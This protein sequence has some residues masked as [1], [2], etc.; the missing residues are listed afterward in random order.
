MA[1]K[2]NPGWSVVLKKEARGAR[3]STA[4]VELCLGQEESHGDR[5]V[6]TIME[7]DRR[8]AGEENDVVD[9]ASPVRGGR[10]LRCN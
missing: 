3:I 4:G 1:D 8:E 9:G 10:R 2:A 6:F 5:E 7:G